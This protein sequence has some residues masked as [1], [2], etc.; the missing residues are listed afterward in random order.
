M[1]CLKFD[2]VV[3]EIFIPFCPLNGH[4]RPLARSLVNEFQLSKTIISEKN[5]GWEKV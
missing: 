3:P 5:G 1:D 4:S 2:F